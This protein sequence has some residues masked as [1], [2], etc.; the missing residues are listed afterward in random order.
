V[1]LGTVQT[2][3]AE[4]SATVRAKRSKNKVKNVYLMPIEKI[5]DDGHHLTCCVKRPTGVQEKLKDLTA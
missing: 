4:R 3:G 2:V 5:E 1:E